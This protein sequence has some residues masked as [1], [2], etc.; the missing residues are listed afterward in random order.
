MCDNLRALLFDSISLEFSL[1]LSIYLL[2]SLDLTIYDEEGWGECRSI[3]IW[4]QT[5][6]HFSLFAHIRLLFLQC[7]RATKPS[8]C[9]PLFLVGESTASICYS[10]SIFSFISSRTQSGLIENGFATPEH[11]KC[12]Q[13]NHS[14]KSYYYK[15]YVSF[16]F[17]LSKNPQFMVC[18]CYLSVI[19]CS[20]PAVTIP[21]FVCEKKQQK[22]FRVQIG[23]S[24]HSLIRTTSLKK[25]YKNQK[26]DIKEKSAEIEHWIGAN[27][28]HNS[29]DTFFG[30]IKIKS[31]YNR[32]F[33][34]RLVI[35]N[36]HGTS[37]VPN[38]VTRKNEAF[39]RKYFLVLS[40]Y[41][42]LP[43][44]FLTQG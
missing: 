6:I 33:S 5:Y 22:T 11:R 4:H 20:W 1:W 2:M 42:P 43:S 31:S 17:C 27:A 25:E 29:F 8:I 12:I 38:D 15:W 9:F 10:L 23:E 28:A 37:Y 14:P 30:A 24:T 39:L 7:H 21:N 13:G 35:D 44:P 26:S 18:F 34:L 41:P 3:L 32:I 40:L 36:N 19:W 16:F